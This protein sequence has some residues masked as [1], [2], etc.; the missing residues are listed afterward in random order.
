VVEIPLTRTRWFA[1]ACLILAMALGA[2]HWVAPAFAGFV[3]GYLIYDIT[4]Y[5]TH[6]F[7]MRRGFLK[8][9]KDRLDY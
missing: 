5:A 9:L 1:L 3:A 2:P 6:H 7:P 8:S 4:H